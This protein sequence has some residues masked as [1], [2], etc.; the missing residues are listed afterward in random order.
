[1]AASTV[2]LLRRVLSHAAASSILCG[3]DGSISGNGSPRRGT[4]GLAAEARLLER[5]AT[6]VAAV[7]DGLMAGEYATVVVSKTRL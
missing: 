3:E 1:M 5:M 7:L 2:A 4:R 6:A